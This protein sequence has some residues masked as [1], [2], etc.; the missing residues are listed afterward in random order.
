MPSTSSSLKQFD[1]L[2]PGLLDIPVEALH[3]LVPEPALFHLPGK[4][5][6]TLFVSVL[7]HGNESTGFLA[8]QQL[9]QKYREQSLRAG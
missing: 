1:N 9:L 8:V 5:P 6:E 3:T 7:L 2:P 4:R